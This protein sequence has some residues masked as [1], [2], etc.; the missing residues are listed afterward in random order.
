MAK[1]GFSMSNRVAVEQITADRTLTV[2][3]CGKVLVV[4]SRGT[5]ALTITLPD[6][7]A[8]ED[9]WNCTVLFESGSIVEDSTHVQNVVI[10]SSQD[11]SSDGNLFVRSL[12]TFQSP[13]VNG[14]AGQ[15]KSVTAA[16]A[17]I[18][19]GDRIDVLIVKGNALGSK[20]HVNAISSASL[21]LG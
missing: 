9:G 1:N 19:T 8:A 15:A 17:S 3:D 18:Q 13:H 2:N 7:A 14:E 12:N 4:D 5:S 20:Y 16:A 10:T 21:T 6:P 11:D